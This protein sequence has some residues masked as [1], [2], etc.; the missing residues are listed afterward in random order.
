MEYKQFF[1]KQADFDLFVEECEKYLTLLG[2]KKAPVSFSF[3]TPP[4]LDSTHLAGC[5]IYEDSQKILI[6]LSPIWNR[7]I[8]EARIKYEALHECIELMLTEKFL[9]FAEESL[10]EGKI[11]QKRWAKAVHQALNSIIMLHAPELLKEITKY[12]I[13]AV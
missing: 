2:L 8:T 12:P 11:N 10:E 5:I 7:E 4:D 1:L 6:F 9:T 3:E 13:F